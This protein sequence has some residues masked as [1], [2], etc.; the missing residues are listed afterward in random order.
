MS[1]TVLKLSEEALSVNIVILQNEKKNQE[2]KTKDTSADVKEILA[3][4][5]IT[6]FKIPFQI[7]RTCLS[8]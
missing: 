1:L 4:N 5:S 3:L 8:R 6:G 2:G 7:K